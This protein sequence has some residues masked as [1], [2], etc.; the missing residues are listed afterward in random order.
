MWPLPDSLSALK[1]EGKVGAWEPRSHGGY[2]A[3]GLLWGQVPGGRG[4]P[5]ASLLSALPSAL[6]A[7]L[8]AR[9]SELEEERLK[10][11]TVTRSQ[12]QNGPDCSTEA[13]P[14][15]ALLSRAWPLCEAFFF[16]FKAKEMTYLHAK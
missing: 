3:E 13:C 6:A 10:F 1:H 2:T 4:M 7:V 9:L 12:L 5:P 11:H 16:S 14:V 15:W 8:Q